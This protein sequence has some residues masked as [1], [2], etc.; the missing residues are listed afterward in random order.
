VILKI[1]YLYDGKKIEQCNSR[2]RH[3]GSIPA[4]AADGTATVDD[5]SGSRH[6]RGFPVWT[7]RNS[8]T[9]PGGE[10]S[11]LR[12]GALWTAPHPVVMEDERYPFRIPITA[13]AAIAIQSVFS[14]P[15]MRRSQYSHHSDYRKCGDHNTVSIPITA[16]AAITI[17]SAFR[18]PQMRRSQ[19]SQHSDYRKCGD[20]NT[21]SIPITANAAIAMASVFAPSTWKFVIR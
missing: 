16:N 12:A 15:Q 7:R 11:N 4:T 1:H 8:G 3:A 18:L 21:V 10:G 9:V 13:N 17:Q 5:T 14:L 19:Y 20:H 2:N 6:A